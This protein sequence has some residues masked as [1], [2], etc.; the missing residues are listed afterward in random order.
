MK[1]P[2]VSVST[3]IFGEHRRVVR[4]E[5]GTSQVMPPAAMV[6]RV[7][8]VPPRRG[9]PGRGRRFAPKQLEVLRYPKILSG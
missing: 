4:G 3:I 7:P 9:I 8:R 1:K 6:P 5:F 2:Y